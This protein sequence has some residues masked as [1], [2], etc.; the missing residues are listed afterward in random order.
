MNRPPSRKEIKLA[1]DLYRPPEEKAM[2]TNRNPL[3]I[4]PRTGDMD[5][6][7]LADHFIRS[8]FFKDVTDVSRAVVK[9]MYGAEL[10]IGPVTAMTA[11]NVIQGKP[12][13]SA[14]LMASL[15]KR[16]GRYNYRVTEHTA[17]KCAIEFYEDGQPCGVSEFTIAEAKTAGLPGK[18]PTWGNY[19]KALLFARALSQG[20]RWY[21]A[22]VFGTSVY[23]PEELGEGEVVEHA[24]RPVNIVTGEVI[25]RSSPAVKAPPERPE[26]LLKALAD[27]H[28]E[29]EEAIASGIE[30]AQRDFDHA[31]HDELRESSTRLLKLRGAATAAGWP[32]IIRDAHDLGLEPR[33]LPEMTGPKR[34]AAAVEEWAEK[35][36]AKRKE[37]AE[38]G[39]EGPVDAAI[40]PVISDALFE[41]GEIGEETL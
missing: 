22:D 34:L 37:R 24:G 5:V 4:V 26:A 25:E 30:P 23:T 6:L 32:Q 2:V 27:W 3:A 15:I 13:P 19:P 28:R 36:E 31:T 35:V 8:G 9:I 1:V 11:I 40:K 14:G 18:N 39:E 33:S 7:T 16:S 17:E 20:A 21:C 12:A 41:E 29:C 38:A 10:G